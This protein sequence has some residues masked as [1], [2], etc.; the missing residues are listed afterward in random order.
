MSVGRHWHWSTNTPPSG[1]L[2][3]LTPPP[4]GRLREL[5]ER[6]NRY[7][8]GSAAP[9]AQL[10]VAVRQV[11]IGPGHVALLLEDGRVCRLAFS[12][13][14]ERLDLSKQDPS[15][16]AL[17]KASGRHGMNAELD[18]FCS[19]EVNLVMIQ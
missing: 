12:V 19:A 18:C 8:Q 15:F 13:I 1:T 3:R 4:G 17:F 7:G 11:A 10:R 9:L 14:T 16:K 2:Y 5:A 6:I